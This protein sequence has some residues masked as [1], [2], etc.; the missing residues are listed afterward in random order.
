MAQLTTRPTGDDVVAFID[1]IADERRRDDARAVLALIEQATKAPA[2]LWGSSIVGFGTR[3]YTTT[4]GSNDWFVV[5]FSPRK[6]ALTIYGVHD[7]D[8][9]ADDLLEQLGP[10]TTGKACLYVKRLADV[11]RHIL[12]QLVQ[13]AWQRGQA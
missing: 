4:T 1:S 7:D 3:R 11:D 10:H 13:R 12:E 8:G 6:A 5:G 2:V 9:P